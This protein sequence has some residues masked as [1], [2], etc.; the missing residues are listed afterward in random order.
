V[1]TTLF[2]A[3][4][5]RLEA[6]AEME[7]LVA[8]GTLRLALKQ[9]GLDAQNLT[10]SQLRVVFEKLM[11]KE[12]EARGITDVAATCKTVMGDITHAASETEGAAAISPTRSSSAWAG[13]EERARIKWKET[14]ISQQSQQAPST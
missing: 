3:A 5:E 12:L 9:A 10:L 6:S 11:P 13:A 2:D 4:A 8:R 1:A 7:R 14:A